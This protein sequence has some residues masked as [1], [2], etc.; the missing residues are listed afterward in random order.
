MTGVEHDSID[1]VSGRATIVYVSGAL[2]MADPP[3]DSITAIVYTSF[4][5]GTTVNV[6]DVPAAV[7]DGVVSAAVVAIVKSENK[8]LTVPPADIVQV[9][10][11][12]L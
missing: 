6:N 11:I 1:D 10:P 9:M 5:P 7:P 2:L 4:P 3:L 12:P 8:L